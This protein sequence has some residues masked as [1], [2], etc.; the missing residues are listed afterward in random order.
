MQYKKVKVRRQKLFFRV[1][2][3]YVQKANGRFIPA[4][5]A[6]YSIYSNNMIT[7]QELAG[8]I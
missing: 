2:S 1:S 6:D 7:A 5:V 4:V 8:N 3:D